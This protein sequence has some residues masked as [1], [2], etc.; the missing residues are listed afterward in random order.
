MNFERHS[1]HCRKLVVSWECLCT[2]RLSDCSNFFA[3]F[4]RKTYCLIWVYSHFV[5]ESYQ[6]KPT[7]P[8]LQNKPTKPNVPNQTYQTYQPNLPIQTYQTKPTK[9]NL[10]NH[11]YQTKHTNL[12]LPNQATL[13]IQTYQTKPA[14]QTYQTKSNFAY[15]AYLTKPAIQT[16]QTK[17]NFAYQAYF[18]KPTKPKL[19]VKAVNAWVRSAFG[20][21]SSCTRGHDWPFR[22]LDCYHFDSTV[23]LGTD[24]NANWLSCKSCICTWCNIIFFSWSLSILNQLVPT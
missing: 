23:W 6:I 3:D 12:N 17:S 16:F 1:E 21:V 9:L 22:C 11:T 2:D 13:P 4:A 10:L 19:L 14:I 18:N 20:N 7:K 8:N 5:F 24:S 15:Q